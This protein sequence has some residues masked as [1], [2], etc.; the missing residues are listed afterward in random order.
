MTNKFSGIKDAFQNGKIG[1]MLCVEGGHSIDSRLALLRIYYE[2]G[3][4]Y[5]TLTH[6]CNTPWA[7]AAQTETPILRLTEFGKVFKIYIFLFSTIS[8]VIDPI[9]K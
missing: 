4:R 8:K 6:S 7:D 2:L 3:V 5:M 9:I 1:S